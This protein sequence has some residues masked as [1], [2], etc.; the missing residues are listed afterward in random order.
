MR[1]M[2]QIPIVDPR[3]A[4]RAIIESEDVELLRTVADDCEARGELDAARD[5]RQCAT[6]IE[7]GH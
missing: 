2:Y 1:P 4:L 6:W 7:A 5:L 3:T